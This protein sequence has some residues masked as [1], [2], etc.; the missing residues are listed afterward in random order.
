MH[1]HAVRGCGLRL[2]V[3]TVEVANFDPPHAASAFLFENLRSVRRGESG[4]QDTPHS[5]PTWLELEIE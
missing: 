1:E 3:L 4:P 2:C 5:E